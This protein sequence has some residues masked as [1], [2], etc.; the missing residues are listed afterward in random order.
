[1][2]RE[3]SRVMSQE[4]EKLRR[5]SGSESRRDESRN[6]ELKQANQGVISQ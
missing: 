2:E 6:G 3:I 1:M 4:K 5:E